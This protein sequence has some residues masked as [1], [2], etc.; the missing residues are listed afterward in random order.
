VYIGQKKI[1]ISRQ[2][3][4]TIKEHAVILGTT[5]KRRK[6]LSKTKVSELLVESNA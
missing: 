2:Y 6:E 4:N 5:D 1:P 3:R